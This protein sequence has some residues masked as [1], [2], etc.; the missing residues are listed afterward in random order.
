MRNMRIGML[1]GLCCVLPAIGLAA[2]IDVT[3]VTSPLIGHPAKPFS[4]EFELDDGNSFFFGPSG[5]S[6][7]S[8]A[9]ATAVAGGAGFN[10]TING[11][12]FA[13]DTV[14]FV[15]NTNRDATFVNANTLM[16]A[17]T[18][19]DIKAAGIIQVVLQNTTPADGCA[20]QVFATPLVVTL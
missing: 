17:I 14:V 1:V 10:L 12:G 16:V 6:P 3:L 19:D 7:V 9:P 5:H 11:T 18:A 2:A 13:A 4:L 20:A 8:K 15:G